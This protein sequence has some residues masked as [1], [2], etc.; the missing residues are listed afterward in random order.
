MYQAKWEN[1]FLQEQFLLLC[2]CYY[3]TQYKKYVWH[4]IKNVSKHFFLEHFLFSVKPS[5]KKSVFSCV[6]LSKK[7]LIHKKIFLY[8][9]LLPWRN[10]DAV[11]L[12]QYT[13]NAAFRP[14]VVKLSITL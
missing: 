14:L 6:K 5:E 4:K 11:Y 1:T 12:I 3:E 2:S 7:K 9:S 8:S 10:V 13:S